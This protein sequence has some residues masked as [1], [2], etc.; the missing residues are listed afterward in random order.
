[1]ASCRIMPSKQSHPNG[2]RCHRRKNRISD[3]QLARDSCHRRQSGSADEQL[4]RDKNPVS[5]RSC[6]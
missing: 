4:A 2:S 5:D 6:D 3:E 1:M